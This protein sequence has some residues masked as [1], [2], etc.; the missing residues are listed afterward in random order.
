[1]SILDD[2]LPNFIKKNAHENETK[3]NKRQ[4]PKFKQANSPKEVCHMEVREPLNIE[5]SI[6]R[7][8]HIN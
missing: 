6:S 2:T 8:K 3:R 1:M 4:G 5:N 7:M